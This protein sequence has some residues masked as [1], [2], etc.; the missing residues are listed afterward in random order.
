MASTDSRPL[1]LK[2]TAFR[3]YFTAYDS[4][5]VPVTAFT[6]PDSERSLDGAAFADCTNEAT[7]VGHGQGYIDLTT[8]EMNTDHTGF[9]F[10]CSEGSTRDC[11]SI[12]PA[13]NDSIPTNVKQI[14]GTA[15]TARDIGASVLLSDGTGTGQID[16]SSGLVNVATL[17]ANSITSSVI[18]TD[19]IGNL[20]VADGFITQSKLNTGCISSDQ[21]ATDAVEEITTAVWAAVTRTLTDGT[22]I[23]LAKGT[24]VTGF[25]DHT[26]AEIADAVC[27]EA[28]SGHA[29]AGT[30][31]KALSDV[32][33]DTGTD[34]VLIS[35]GTA[36][37]Q[38]SLVNGIVSAYDHEGAEI[39]KATNLA[40]VI[41]RLGSFT[42]TGV[43]TVLGMFKAMLSKVAT[44][45]SDVGGTFDP[46]ADSTEAI[47][48]RGDAA[49]TTGTTPPTAAAIADAVCDEAVSDHV[50]AGTVGAQLASIYAAQIDLS[51]D[52]SNTQ[53][54]YSVQWFKNGAPV[55]S[56]VTSPTIQVI[57]RAD[58]TD[59]VAAAAMTEIGSTGAYK[60][61]ATAEA[62]RISAG[63]AVVVHVAATIDGSSRTW[64]KVISRDSAAA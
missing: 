48:D 8:T 29:T 10:S 22:N 31:A 27:D 12:C 6:S 64:R 58:G 49:W 37:G 51:D 36:A 57:K 50:T 62:N 33:A 13:Q 2:N 1:P 35:S 42:G 54:E 34:G 5:G 40:T 47:R 56:G 39:A 25:N 19:A 21:L 53:D 20:Q 43:N 24:G 32:L 4:S 17:A 45:P 15:Q 11:I 44:L 26:T 30:L 9:Y 16:L 63:E 18:A 7:Y 3:L 60:Y 28:L 55:T 38:V 52:E 23:V 59:L 41:S 46:A 14:N 61:D